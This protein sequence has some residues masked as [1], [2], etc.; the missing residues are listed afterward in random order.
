MLFLSSGLA[1]EVAWWMQ[2]LQKAGA[3]AQTGCASSVLVES[4]PSSRFSLLLRLI[5]QQIAAGCLQEM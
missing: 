4:D 1:G 2:P 5:M 3:G